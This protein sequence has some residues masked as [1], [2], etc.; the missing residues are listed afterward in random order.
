MGDF[1][2]LGDLGDLGDISYH[3]PAQHFES[4]AFQ[5]S[6]SPQQSLY[7]EKHLR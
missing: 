3:A 6:P 2:D 1:A 5:P 4:R 7:V